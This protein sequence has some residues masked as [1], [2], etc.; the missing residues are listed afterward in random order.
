MRFEVCGEHGYSLR[1]WGC[2]IETVV[3]SATCFT[4]LGSLGRDSPACT[5]NPGGAWFLLPV[6]PQC[7][8]V[9]LCETGVAVDLR[10]VS[11]LLHNCNGHGVCRETDPSL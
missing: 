1:G 3:P 11:G 8:L 9:E 5:T 7:L 6:P 2:Y 10:E 4:C